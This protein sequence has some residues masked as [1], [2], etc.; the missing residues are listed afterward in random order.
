[1]PCCWPG[2]APSTRAA[3]TRPRQPL[4]ARFVTRSA[5]G[6]CRLLLFLCDRVAL[7]RCGERIVRGGLPAGRGLVL[8]RDLFGGGDLNFNRLIPGTIRSALRD[9]RPIIRSDGKFVRDYV[10]VKDA[11]QA[12]LLLA[13]KLPEGLAG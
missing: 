6:R 7:A 5:A 12:Y 13:E 11:V 10:Y 9:E 2:I 4:A 3:A 1:M 8:Q